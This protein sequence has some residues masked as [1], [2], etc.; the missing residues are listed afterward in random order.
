ML[1]STEIRH[2]PPTAGVA[3][4]RGLWWKRIV[5]DVRLENAGEEKAMVREEPS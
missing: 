3:V 2:R 1:A 5:R 4:R